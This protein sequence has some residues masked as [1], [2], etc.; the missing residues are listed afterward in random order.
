MNLK[1]A[2]A[3]AVMGLM[4][5][6]PVNAFADK[7]ADILNN[8]TVRI[9]V[10]ADSA[11]WGYRDGSGNLTGF[12]IGLANLVAADLGVKLEIVE[13]TGAARLPSLLSDQIDILIAAAGATPERAQQVMFT[14][15]YV[16]TDLGVFGPAS[17]AEFKSPED[18]DGISIA[19]A[20]GTTLDVWLTDNAPKANIVRF[21]DAASAMAAYSA[22]QTQYFAENSVIA[23]SAKGSADLELKFRIRQS[24]AHIAV[25]QGEHNLLQWLNTDLFFNRLNGKLDALQVEFF[26]QASQ[27]PNML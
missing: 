26:G 20:R 5:L 24:P 15:P 12:D 27:V 25:N 17:S 16:A 10:L 21:E 6:A 9:G 1:S 7:L 3:A 18:M 14:A 23:N 8:G 19:V 4:T 11:P 22:G 13:V 2:F